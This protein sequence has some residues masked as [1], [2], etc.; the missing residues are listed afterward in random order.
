MDKVIE[1]GAETCQ[2]S[3]MAL[4]RLMDFRRRTMH[5]T[6]SPPTQVC[7]TQALLLGPISIED[8]Q[9]KKTIIFEVSS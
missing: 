7:S 8:G 4:N 9:E 5:T 6:A 1:I 3:Q 2:T